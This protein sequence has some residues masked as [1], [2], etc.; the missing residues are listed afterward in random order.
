M[1]SFQ[2]ESCEL[3]QMHLLSLHMEPRIHQGCPPNCCDIVTW[4]P[5]TLANYIMSFLDPGE[6]HLEVKLCEFVA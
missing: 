6:C 4:L 2:K 5:P 3:P 1:N